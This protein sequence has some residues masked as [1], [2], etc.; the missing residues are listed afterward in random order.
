MYLAEIKAVRTRSKTRVFQQFFCP[1]C[2][3]E[4]K[5]RG[6]NVPALILITT[7]KLKNNLA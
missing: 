3:Q 7:T 2:N 4:P 5:E 1:I 6:Q